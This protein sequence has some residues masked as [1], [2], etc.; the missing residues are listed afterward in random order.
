MLYQPDMQIT[1]LLILKLT[2]PPPPLHQKE[3]DPLTIANS[4]YQIQWNPGNTTNHGT[5]VGW[6]C[7]RGGR[8]SE[9]E[10]LGTGLASGRGFVKFDYGI[11]DL[12]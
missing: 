12:L 5:D 8:I 9:V 10:N 2:P 11:W 1:L 4:F 3:V 7:Y 6:S